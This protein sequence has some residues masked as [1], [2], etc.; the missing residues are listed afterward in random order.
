MNAS[1]GTRGASVATAGVLHRSVVGASAPAPTTG[2][3][4]FLSK[5][6]ASAWIRPAAKFLLLLCLLTGLSWIGSRAKGFGAYIATPAAPTGSINLA[7]IVATATLARPVDGAD[8]GV[9]EPTDAAPLPR[10]GV[11][12][13]SDG[14]VVLNLANEDELRKLPKVGAKRAAA[15]VALRQRLGRF[16]SVRDLLRVKGIGLRTLQKIQP[17]VVLDPPAD[18]ADAGR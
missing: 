15:I 10:A 9:A 5:L 1:M 13:L 16:R 3:A 2:L 8:G 18:S 4:A 12:V 6:L 14:R 7:S 17:M 11:G